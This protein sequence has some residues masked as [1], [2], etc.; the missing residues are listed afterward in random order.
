MSGVGFGNPQQRFAIAYHQA[1]RLDPDGVFAFHGL[2][3]L[4]DPL[5]RG[6][7]QLRQLFLRQLQPN[8]CLLYTSPSPRD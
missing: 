8:T 2:Q 3:L 6:P 5:A 1:T 4:V 7:E